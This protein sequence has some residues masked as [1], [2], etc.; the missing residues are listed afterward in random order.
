MKYMFVVRTTEAAANGAKQAS[1]EEIF[2][3]FGAYNQTLLSAG[4]LIASE[5]LLPAAEGAVVSFTEDGETVTD[6][7]YGETHELF[8]GYWVVQTS[9]REE[10]IEWAR[11]CPLAPGTKLEVR[12]MADASDLQSFADNEFVAKEAEWRS[13]QGNA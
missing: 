9:S 8:N 4:A 2:Q 13:M 1:P 7:P 5:G 6:G 3:A 11:K 10:A 12:R